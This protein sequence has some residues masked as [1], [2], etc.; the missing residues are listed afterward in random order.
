MF[1]RKQEVP[2]GHSTDYLLC[3]R[4]RDAVEAMLIVIKKLEANRSAD[5]YKDITPIT[6]YLQ[7]L[8]DL[9]SFYHSAPRPKD[10]KTTNWEKQRVDLPMPPVRLPPWMNIG[11][12]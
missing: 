12:S 7:G 9:V 6:D 3:Y 11:G 1:K 4:R 8:E 2:R 10:F 5:A